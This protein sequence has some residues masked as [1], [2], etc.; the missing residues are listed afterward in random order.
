MAAA[1]HNPF[2]NET[3]F[4]NQMVLSHLLP[5]SLWEPLPHF[6][7]TWL[8]N[9][10]A[11]NMLYFISGFLWCF[12]IYYV[13]LNVYVPKESIPTR[14]TMIKHIS[15]AMKAM[16]WQSLLPTVTEYM[17]EHGW[18]LCYSTVDHFNWFLCFLYIALYLALVEFGV[19]FIH[20]ELHDNKFLYKH[21][22]ATHHIYN[23]QKTISPFSAYAFHPLDGIIQSLP[24]VI[25]LFIVPIHLRSH[26]ILLFLEGL[27]TANIHDCIHGDIWPV[28]GAGYHTVHHKTYKHNYG[29]YTIYMDW[30]F[31]SLKAPLAEEEDSF[32]EK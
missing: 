3:S 4:Y 5:S 28:M 22:H 15:V 20:K 10:L 12:Y 26:L 18:T 32:K 13:K 9:Y 19:Y 17:V 23:K 27:W 29:H 31:G 14:K 30:M 16:P 21:L 7:Q 8:R 6:L 11:A 2:V 25:S 1:N 24:H